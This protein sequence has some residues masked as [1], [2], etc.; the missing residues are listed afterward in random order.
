MK[1]FS[2]GKSYEVLR[3][4]ENCFNFWN[5]KIFKTMKIFYIVKMLAKHLCATAKILMSVC[6]QHPDGCVFRNLLMNRET[7]FNTLELGDVYCCL[8]QTSKNL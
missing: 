1:Q 3:Y 8:G 4:D 5:L 6:E 7:V 2:V